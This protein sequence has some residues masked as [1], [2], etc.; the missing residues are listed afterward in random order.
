MA[1]LR[2]GKQKATRKEIKGNKKGN[3]RQQE[4]E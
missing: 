4:G 2:K 1:I 3:K